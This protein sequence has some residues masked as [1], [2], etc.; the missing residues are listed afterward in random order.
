VR[1]GTYQ[2][3]AVAAHKAPLTGNI[4]RKR[5]SRTNQPGDMGATFRIVGQGDVGS[6]STVHIPVTWLQKIPDEEVMSLCS[7][8]KARWHRDNA[9]FQLTREQLKDFETTESSPMSVDERHTPMDTSTNSVITV[10][11]AVTTGSYLGFCVVNSVQH[12]RTAFSKQLT[13]PILGS[14]RRGSCAAR[15]GL[16]NGMRIL[17]IGRTS[18]KHAT[19]MPR[20]NTMDYSPAMKTIQLVS[21]ALQSSSTVT[22]RIG[23]SQTS[24]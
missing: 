22:F 15:A 16:C 7:T 9:P 3:E 2:Q 1:H 12:Q 10:T 20:R 5:K 17:A 13:V 6:T 21:E 19:R 8:K 18:V 4:L 14:V 24:R 23:K 11:F